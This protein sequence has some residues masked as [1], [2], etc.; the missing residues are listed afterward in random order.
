MYLEN[1]KGS[2]M[3]RIAYLTGDYMAAA[4]FSQADDFENETI[5]LQ[6]ELDDANSTIKT[7]E[8]QI[9]ELES[10]TSTEPNYT[11]TLD[12]ALS[13]VAALLQTE[14]KVNKK[15]LLKM[16]LAIIELIAAPEDFT[17]TTARELIAKSFEV[18]A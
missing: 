2:E 8:A 1:L 17:A 13:T 16:T 11:E 5:N 15:A 12:S 18:H 6:N 3:E 10:N 14:G 7:L 4:A 9:E